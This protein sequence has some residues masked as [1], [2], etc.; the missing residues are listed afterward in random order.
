VQPRGKQIRFALVSCVPA[1]VGACGDGTRDAD[2][3]LTSIQS[4]RQVFDLARERSCLNQNR[5]AE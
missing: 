2:D 5:G 3:S 1:Q 4:E